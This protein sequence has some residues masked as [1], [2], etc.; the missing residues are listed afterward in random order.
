M[1]ATKNNF[2]LEIKDIK[3]ND[4]L[5]VSNILAMLLRVSK[6]KERSERS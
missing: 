6:V 4:L 1:I 5:Q 3:K 2:G